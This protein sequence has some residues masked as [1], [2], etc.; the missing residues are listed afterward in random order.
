M[1]MTT[2]VFISRLR[3]LPVVDPDG[4]QLGK[5]RDV[6]IQFG[7][8]GTPPRVR[9]LVV[10]LFAR[11]QIFISIARISAFDPAQVA[12]SGVINTR[13]FQRRNSET[14]VV[15]DLFDSDVR[16]RGKD[17]RYRIFDVAMKML[18]NREW[19]LSEIALVDLSRPRRLGRRQHVVIADWS[20]IVDLGR[21][22]QAT[23][24]LLA[25]LQD[26]HAADVART[27]HDLDPQ[28]RA[29]VVASLDDERLAS[30]L[31]ELPEDEQVQLIS[32]LDAERA[33]DILVEMN[34]DDAADLIKELAPDI[35]EQLLARMEDQDAEGIRQL[36]TYADETAGGMMTTEPVILSPD[37]TVADALARVRNEE[38]TPALA[39]MVYICRPPMEVPTG[40]FI[41]GVHIQRLLREPPSTL[42]S[43]LIA[44][45]LEP[46]ETEYPLARVSRYF[47]TYNLV[48]APV[49]DEHKRLLGA[50]TVDDVID[51]M[52]PEDWR[53]RG[54]D[55]FDPETDDRQAEVSEDLANDRDEWQRSGGER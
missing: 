40:R 21:G 5:V 41:G 55:G 7:R 33:S 9:G 53:G 43:E 27:L 32:L 48:N 2:S 15:D 36:M 12:T 14:L 16:W 31:E 18:R 49:V 47:A 20:E 46:L 50:V 54:M 8:V 29:E 44:T 28:R 37:D 30:A 42:V 3:G 17:G 1:S 35:A 52:L 11:Q 4:D 38:L 22:E 25:E 19:A 24:Q 26:M 13:R 6:V 45:D 34:P 23:D 51:H 10:E 39:G